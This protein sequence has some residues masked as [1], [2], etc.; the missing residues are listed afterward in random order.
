MGQF[1]VVKDPA[2]LKRD[3]SGAIRFRAKMDHPLTAKLLATASNLANTKSPDFGW[4][5]A[6]G[7]PTTLA[8]QAA[9]K[10]VLLYFIEK[11]CP[12]SR[13][14]AVHID[15]LQA[16][17]GSAVKVVG[18]INADGATAADWKAATKAGFP[19]LADADL[20]I[21]GAFQA[22]RSATT[23]LVSPGGA[24]A[25]VNPGYSAGTLQELAGLIARYARLPAPKLTFVGAPEKLTSGCP[26]KE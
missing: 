12:C 13:D 26:L 10:P 23:I 4:T 7:K 9:T 19:V 6:E 21:A 20:A 8:K 5:D 2:S 3:A 16:A 22:E 25:K 1:L 11:E 15:Q 17:L 18:L 24:I 14:A